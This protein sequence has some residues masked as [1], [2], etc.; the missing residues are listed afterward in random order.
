MLLRRRERRGGYL[1][2]VRERIL[3]CAAVAGLVCLMAV[4]VGGAGASQSEVARGVA[5]GAGS[6][7]RRPAALVPSRDRA[8][9]ARDLR[10]AK[11]RAARRRRWLES[12]RVRA[13]RVASRMEFHGLSGAVRSGCWPVIMG[14]LLLG[15]VETIAIEAML[16]EVI[17]HLR[18]AGQRLRAVCDEIGVEPVLMCRVEP[19]STETPAITF[20]VRIVCWAAENKVALDVD[21]LIWRKDDDSNE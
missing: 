11:A 19:K 7:L 5:S 14:R 15:P 4:L 12:P 10:L 16:D 2:Q 6:R 1:A 17:M 9:L 13:Q 20:P 3:A 8:A 18:P 21:I